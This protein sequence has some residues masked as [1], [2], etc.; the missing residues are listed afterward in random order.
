MFHLS[1]RALGASLFAVL[2]SSAAVAQQMA[3]QT[4]P[5]RIRGTVEKVDGNTLEIKARDGKMMTVKL[6]DNARVMAFVKASMADIKANSYIGVTAMPEADGSQR[7][8]AIH[9]FTEAQRG[10]GEGFRQWDLRPGSTMTN[11]AVDNIVTGKDGDTVTVKYKDGEKKVIVDKA[12]AIVAYAAG[13]KGE[14]KAGTPVIIFAAAKQADGTYTA[15]AVSFG[16]GVTPP[17]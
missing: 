17:M 2:L 15:P 3:P 8:I 16:R 12:T 6:A 1:R 14:I 7:A 10:T 13:E 4:P 11:A 5:T 9:I